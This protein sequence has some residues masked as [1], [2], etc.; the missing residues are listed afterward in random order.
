MLCKNYNYVAWITTC[1]ILYNI[2]M[3]FFR[4]LFCWSCFGASAAKHMK[5]KYKKYYVHMFWTFPQ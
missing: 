3:V 4:I 1:L 5:S 2:E